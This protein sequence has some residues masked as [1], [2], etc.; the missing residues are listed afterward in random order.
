ME[1]PSQEQLT[2]I[3]RVDLE[4]G[5]L[6]WK[7]PPKNHP[8]LIGAEAGSPLPNQNKKLY[9]RVKINRRPFKRGHIIYFLALGRWPVPCLDHRDGDSLNDSI[10]N[11]RAATITQNA[12]NHKRRSRRIKLP[13][14]V[15]PLS[16]GRFSARIGYHGSQ[17]S[18]GSFETPEQAQAAYL[19]KR[20]ELYREF[21]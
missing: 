2:R 4:S 13:M 14:G 6:F 15:R 20:K 5:K 11:L 8:R 9:W 18:L 12:W 1:H 10:H 7:E 17:L 19:A 21:A 3:F 16:S